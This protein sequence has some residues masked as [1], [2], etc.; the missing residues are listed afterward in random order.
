MN[1]I[2]YFAI[3]MM[4]VYLFMYL[5]IG[6]RKRKLSKDVIQLC[7][8]SSFWNEDREERDIGSLFIVVICF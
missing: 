5:Y 2:L 1:D 3:I 4:D 6:R 7:N 8:I